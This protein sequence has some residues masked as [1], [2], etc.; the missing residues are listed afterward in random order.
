MRKLGWWGVI[1]AMSV[2]LFIGTTAAQQTPPAIDGS[3]V[4]TDGRDGKRYNTVV[5]GGKRWMGE[6]LNYQTS[7]G[8]WCYDNDNSNCGKYGRLYDWKTAKTVCPAGFHLPSRQE[9]DDL[10][11]AAGGKSAAGKKLKARS[12][13]SRDGNG[14][15][16]YGFS[17]LPGGGRDPGGAFGFV[18]KDGYWWAASEYGSDSAYSRGMYYS[19]DG[20][21]ENDDDKSVGFSVRCLADN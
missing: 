17:A 5:I 13:W 14:T 19:Y 15:D 11:S 3:G 16:D 2:A 18:G 9:W 6:N 8:S 4:L 20:V 1:A 21:N 12:G 7:S 10:V